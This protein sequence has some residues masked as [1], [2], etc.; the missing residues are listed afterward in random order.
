MSFENEADRVSKEVSKKV[1]DAIRHGGSPAI[2][3]LLESFPQEMIEKELA[4]IA[5][6][7]EQGFVT[8]A[9]WARAHMAELM[10]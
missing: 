2:E 4:L 5:G 7:F 9:L 1:T 3:K 10:S 8:G 6:S